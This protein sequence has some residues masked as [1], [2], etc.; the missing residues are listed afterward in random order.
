MFNYDSLD[1]LSNDEKEAFH[2][3]VIIHSEVMSTKKNISFYFFIIIFSINELLKSL[4]YFPNVNNHH[5]MGNRCKYWI[6]RCKHD[7]SSNRRVIILSRNF[8][9]MICKTFLL[10]DMLNIFC[11]YLL[12][13]KFD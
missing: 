6:I 4:D 8:I 10:L 5:Y 3:I 2:S 12:S 7:F 1:F 9:F 13:S 11:Y